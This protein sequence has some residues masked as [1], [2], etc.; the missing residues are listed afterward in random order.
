MIAEKERL[1][2]RA[3]REHFLRDGLQ[4][5]QWLVLQNPQA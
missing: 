2:L 4:G 5:H 3:A 1:I